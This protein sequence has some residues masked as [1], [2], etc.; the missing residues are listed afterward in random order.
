MI[1]ENEEAFVDIYMELASLV[2]LKNAIILYQN[3]KGQQITFPMRLYRTDYV[4]EE[5]KK[6]YN[7]ENLKDLA[8]EYGY[9]ER[10]LRSLL[11]ENESIPRDNERD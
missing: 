7:G 10:H 11:K 6:R 8:K 9:S 5:I 4:A 2:G 3:F 1:I